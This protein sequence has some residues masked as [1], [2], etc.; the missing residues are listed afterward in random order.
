LSVSPNSSSTPRIVRLD[1]LDTDY[2]KIV[3]GET[4]PEDKKRRL[5]ADHYNF[6][7]LGK[8]IAR[9]RHGSLDR[10]GL[11]D[12]LCSIGTTAELFRG[13]DLE[14]FNDRLRRTGC[15]YLTSGERQQVINWLQDELGVDLRQAEPG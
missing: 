5:A 6:E 4:I 2:A 3:A 7:Q 10:Q 9:Y 15:F 11:D 12:V 1:M 13:S 8:Q 14:D